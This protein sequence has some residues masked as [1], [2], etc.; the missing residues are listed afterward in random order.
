MT[1]IEFLEII[2]QLHVGSIA[3][4][5]KVED[6]AESAG[7]VAQVSRFTLTSKSDGTTSPESAELIHVV[8]PE[9]AG[10]WRDNLP[11]NMPA[12]RVCQ[13]VKLKPSAEAEYRELHAAVWP[14]VLA[15]L[16]RA[17]VTD[18]SIHYYR[19][20]GLLVANFKYI[21]SD[22]EADMKKVAEDPETQRWRKVTDVLQETLV[23]GA[24]GSGGE[25][26]WWAEA[27][28]VFRFEGKA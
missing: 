24:T 1:S 8:G 11:L 27:E 7:V 20:L 9:R 6:L 14:A 18:Y 19:P 21:G 25:I 2:K 5:I 13:L 26:P 15:A 12:K 28:E 17:H 3:K 23:D 4:L 22:Y 16:E 10:R